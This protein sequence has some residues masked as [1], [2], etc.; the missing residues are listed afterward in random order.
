[1]AQMYVL[2]NDD[3]GNDVGCL[4]KQSNV[5]DTVLKFAHSLVTTAGLPSICAA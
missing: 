4:P 1:M 5:M 2:H 3:V